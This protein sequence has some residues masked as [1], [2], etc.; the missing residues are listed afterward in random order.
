[1]LCHRNASC[2]FCCSYTFSLICIGCTKL[3]QESAESVLLAIY[4]KGVE[5]S[6]PELVTGINGS[7]VVWPDFFFICEFEQY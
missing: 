4:E 3:S 6:L 1:M 7:Q 2:R 5:T